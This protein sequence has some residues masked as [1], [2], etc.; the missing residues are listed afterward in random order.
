MDIIWRIGEA[1]LVL[2]MVTLMLYYVANSRESINDTQEFVTKQ[3]YS[4]AYANRYASLS[5]FDADSV[6]KISVQEALNLIYNYADDSTPVIVKGPDG[7]IHVYV[8][9]QGGWIYSSKGKPLGQKLDANGQY[10]NGQYDTSLPP[11]Q[12]AT[13]AV[14][15]YKDLYNYLSNNQMSEVHYLA[16]INPDNQGTL[17]TI[18][19]KATN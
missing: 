13:E 10:Y 15:D 19:L 18:L 16:N 11:L 14:P 12:I 5:S 9:G 8:S 2:L 17:K 1:L 4:D 7:V 6:G 3:N